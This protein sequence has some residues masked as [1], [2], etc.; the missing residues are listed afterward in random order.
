MKLFYIFGTSKRG[1]GYSV[2]WASSLSDIQK[3]VPVPVAEQV[4]NTIFLKPVMF[5][6]AYNL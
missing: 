4:I 2:T 6:C 5:P 3:T 1:F